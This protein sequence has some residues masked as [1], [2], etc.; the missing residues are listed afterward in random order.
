[1]ANVLVTI[2]KATQVISVLMPVTLEVALKL[3]ALFAK[4]GPDIQVDIKQMQ[5]DA[6]VAADETIAMIDAWMKENEGK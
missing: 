3:K 4:I 2:L 1:M 5:A 6:V